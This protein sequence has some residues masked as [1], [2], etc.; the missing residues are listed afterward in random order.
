M[1]PAGADVETS[2]PR[3]LVAG[4]KRINSQAD[5]QRLQNTNGRQSK[6][7]V[8]RDSRPVRSMKKLTTFS[9]RDAEYHTCRTAV[10]NR[11]II[12]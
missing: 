5:R 9:K 2:S 6:R 7:I 10:S 8:A 4:H 1:L 3:L 12:R 11:L